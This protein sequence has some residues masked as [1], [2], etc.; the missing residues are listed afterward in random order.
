MKSNGLV[1]LY[2]IAQFKPHK[3]TCNEDDVKNE[4]AE[5]TIIMSR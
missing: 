1:S 4:L 2:A 5:T 3:R